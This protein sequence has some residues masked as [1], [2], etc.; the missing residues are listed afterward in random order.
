[1]T[2]SNT[3]QINLMPKQLAFVSDD[4]HRELMYSGAYGAGK[5]FALCTRAIRK[6]QYPGARVAIVRKTYTSLRATTLRTLIEPDGDR[7]P[8]L[9]EG[10][11]TF[12]KDEGRL[13]VNAGGEIVLIGCDD[14][15]K[16]GSQQ[17]SDILI[18]EGIELDEHEYVMLLGRLRVRYTLP[19]GSENVRNI[20][21]ATNPGDPGHFLY[22][23]FIA[24]PKMGT[25]CI[26]TCTAENYYLPEDYVESL[27]DLAGSFRQRYFMGDWVAL[28]GAIHPM[29]DSRVHVCHDP[30]P[31]DYYLAGVDQGFV[32]P[33]V[34]RVHGCR[35]GSMQSHVVSEFYEKG[36]I[37]P[38]LVEYALLTNKQFGPCTF[39][40]DSAA[41]D[42]RAQ[43]LQAG[44]DVV[45]AIKDVMP[46]I[47]QVQG[48]LSYSEGVPP[49]LTMEPDLEGNK[50]YPA[51]RWRRVMDGS[52]SEEPLKKN[53]HAVDADRYVRMYMAKGERGG[54]TDLGQRG[55]R[56]R[57]PEGGA[58]NWKT[59]DSP[60]RELNPD[61]ERLWTPVGD[62][63]VSEWN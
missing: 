40:I 45:L 22:D 8:L 63:G 13:F 26:H 46:G 4:Q 14:E 55:R 23:R 36:I 12:K 25:H 59:N 51:Y 58:L 52:I 39:V 32:N 31:W 44:L 54:L 29:F 16:V 7:L 60:I 27:G 43:M 49:L 34:I 41:A 57:A 11:Y 10:T 30:G 2:D 17:F 28:E 21:T 19:D 3:V 6:A 56:R 50:E 48:D 18:D 42:V 35:L 1:M 15:L 9:P 38:R 47:R 24:H 33:S 5:S 62:A 61:D 20:C 53:D 37:S